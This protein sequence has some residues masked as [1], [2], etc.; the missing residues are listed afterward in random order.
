[1]IP[2]VEA[3]ARAQDGAAFVLDQEILGLAR[4]P[5]EREAPQSGWQRPA[6]LER[7]EA[8]RV[9]RVLRTHTG[10]SNHRGT[11]PEECAAFH[12]MKWRSGRSCSSRA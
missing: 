6:R 10:C 3:S 1:M 11:D 4:L 8:H 2:E 12:R 7:G 9:D 5:L